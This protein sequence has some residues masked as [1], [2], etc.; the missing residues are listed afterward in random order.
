MNEKALERAN[1]DPARYLAVEKSRIP[2]RATHELLLFAVA[3]LARTRPEE[4]AKHLQSHALLLGAD[5]TRYGWSQIAHAAAQQHHPRAV[6]WYAEAGEGPFTDAQL[7]WKARAALRAG[8]WA[9]VRGGGEPHVAGRGPRSRLALLARPVARLRG[10][11]RPPPRRSCSRS[12]GNGT[13]TA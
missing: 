7:Q 4:A 5:D 8:D 11:A 1:A 9:A 6:E 3:R 12:R 2:T 13:S 10:R